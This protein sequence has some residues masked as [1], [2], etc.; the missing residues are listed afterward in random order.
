MSETIDLQPAGGNGKPFLVCDAAIYLR[1]IGSALNFLLRGMNGLVSDS[2]YYTATDMTRL[3][4]KDQIGE[5]NRVL[6]VLCE[7][8]A[9]K[10][11]HALV[12]VWEP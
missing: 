7:A 5:I 8:T 11:G 2:D 10:S 4:V 12:E 1:D 6:A 9:G 3:I